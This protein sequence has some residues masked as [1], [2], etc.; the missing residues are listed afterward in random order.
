MALLQLPNTFADESDVLWVCSAL[1]CLEMKAWDL[2]PHF[3]AW[4][5][6]RAGNNPAYV[7]FFGNQFHE[8]PGVAVNIAIWARARAEWARDQLAILG[9]GL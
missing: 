5:P 6:G 1:N 7:S 8:I 9:A 3:G 4:C 2:P